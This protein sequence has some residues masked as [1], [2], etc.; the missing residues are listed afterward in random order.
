MFRIVIWIS[1]GIV[2]R[3]WV[4]VHR[5]HHAN[6]DV[7]GD[8]HSPIVDTFAMVQFANV[9]LYKKATRDGQTVRKYAKD[10]VPDTWDRVLFDRSLLGL[11]I[12]ISALFLLF[13]PWVALFASLIHTVSYLLL[14]AAVNAIGHTYGER[15]YNN[16]ATNNNWLAILTCGEGLHNNHHAAPTASKM[17]FRRNQIDPGWWAIKLLIRTGQAKVRLESPKLTSAATLGLSSD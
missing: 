10:M 16:L 11:G 2:P 3:E 6:T 5:K 12:G 14:S 15:P 7:P 9:Y 1:T 13:G 17:S 8:P 4:A